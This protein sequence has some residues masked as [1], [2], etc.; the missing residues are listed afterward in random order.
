MRGR[1][2]AVVFNPSPAEMY[3][4]ASPISSSTSPRSTRLERKHRPGHFRGVC[5]V[6]TKLFNIIRPDVAIFGQKDY[7]QLRILSAMVEAL[8]FPIQI[9]PGPTM[10]TRTDW[11]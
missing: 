9:V 8:N 10:R 4:P 7:Q 3:R 5:Q 2:C 6:V 11:P 1:R